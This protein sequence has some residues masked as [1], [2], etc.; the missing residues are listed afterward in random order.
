MK[1]SMAVSH[2]LLFAVSS[3]V[4][5]VQATINM[6][7]GTINVT[8][9]A[10]VNGTCLTPTWIGI[11]DGTVD[12]YN[13]SEAASSE[14]ERV[15]EDGDMTMFIEKAAV[16]PGLKYQ[17]VVGAGNDK[18]HCGLRV[19]EEGGGKGPIC[20]GQLSILN[21]DGLEIHAGAVHYF[22]YFAMVLP[23]NDAW[24][25][26]G[27]LLRAVLGK[28]ILKNSYF[29]SKNFL[30]FLQE[31]MFFSSR[32]C[33]FFQPYFRSVVIFTQVDFLIFLEEYL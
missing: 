29:F 31:Y 4:A 2:S 19:L 14:L 22:L 32:N 21:I 28:N 8:N 23:S 33:T 11:H 9:M 16:E 15:V 24:V 17:S 12:I 1:L 25:A 3:N 30:I 5:L 20:G 26:N 27:D 7:Q 18:K 10:P 6:F 13:K